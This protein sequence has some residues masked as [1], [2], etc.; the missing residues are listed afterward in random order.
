MTGQQQDNRPNAGTIL[1]AAVIAIGA[2]MLFREASGYIPGF[3]VIRELMSRVAWA[4]VLIVAGVAIIAWSRGGGQGLP[5]PREGAK[6]Y[7]S[8]DDK[9]VAGVLGGLARYFDMDS[10]IVRLIFIVAVIA[11]DFGALVIAYLVMALLVPVD[12]GCKEDGS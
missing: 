11:L 7:R 12:P 4:A 3:E 1:G 10:T 5:K 9:W 8:C 2:W 6:L